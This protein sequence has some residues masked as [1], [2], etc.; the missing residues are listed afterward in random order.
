MD[1]KGAAAMVRP[2]LA[3]GAG[4]GLGFVGR[5]KTPNP[6]GGVG[7]AAFRATKQIDGLGFASV[8]AGARGAEQ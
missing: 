8:G 1:N 5:G 3:D 4:H 7:G 6:A 2:P